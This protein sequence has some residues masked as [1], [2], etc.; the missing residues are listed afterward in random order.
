MSSFELE[1]NEKLKE[2]QGTL[3]DGSVEGC[4]GG[5]EFRTSPC[6]IHDIKIVNEENVNKFGDVL[7]TITDE[8]LTPRRVTQW[9]GFEFICPNCGINSILVN[10]Y[11]A[12]DQVVLC[13]N[14]ECG[15][16][17]FVQSSIVNK[18]VEEVVALLRQK[19]Q[20]RP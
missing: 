7:T 19:N 8:D 20:G 2:T 10:S 15:K 1:E 9:V 4:N 13:V 11:T 14:P 12:P 5:N 16:K 18:K 3:C 6:P 17:A